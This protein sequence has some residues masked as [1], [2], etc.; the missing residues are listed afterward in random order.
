LSLDAE[1]TSQRET[2]TPSP[3]RS[4]R[5]QS[6]CGGVLTVSLFAFVDAT[7]SYPWDVFSESVIFSPDSRYT[8][9]CF[10]QPMK[11][12][13]IPD[14]S[15][16]VPLH[17][18]FFVLKKIF[19]LQTPDSPTLLIPFEVS[20][21]YLYSFHSLSGVERSPSPMPPPCSGYGTSRFPYEQVFQ[22]IDF[23]HPSGFP[24]IMPPPFETI[25]F[26]DILWDRSRMSVGFP[27]FPIMRPACP[28]RLSKARKTATSFGPPPPRVLQIFPPC[29]RHLPWYF[30][31]AFDFYASPNPPNTKLV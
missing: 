5:L 16:H 12:F 29:N 17:N 22:S 2:P 3:G 1:I 25:F 11:F 27:L 10:R 7:Y 6:N 26:F 15:R 14:N 31:R 24:P 30:V 4:W 18:G 9:F 23:F 21:G 20:F 28:R 13:I 8:T 19:A